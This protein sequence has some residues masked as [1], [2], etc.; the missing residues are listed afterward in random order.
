M[1]QPKSLDYDWW[2]KNKPKSI[3]GAAVEPL[4]K[5]LAGAQADKVKMVK[6]YEH[7]GELAVATKIGASIDAMAKLA[8]ELKRVSVASLKEKHADFAKG[9]E[10]LAAFATADM[11]AVAAALDVADKKIKVASGKA[12]DITAANMTTAAKVLKDFATGEKGLL[13][14]ATKAIAT[15]AAKGQKATTPDVFKQAFGE[16]KFLASWLDTRVKAVKTDVKGLMADLAKAGNDDAAFAK[17]VK[18]QLAVDALNISIGDWERLKDGLEKVDKAV[19][20]IAAKVLGKGPA[21]KAYLDAIE[22]PVTLKAPKAT[23]VGLKLKAQP[24]T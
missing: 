16:S 22:I 24:K 3:Q 23:G 21:S 9:C 10:K 4:I 6:M 11:K 17:G 13:G 15:V 8:T 1:D 14:E 5:E 7:S 2:K 19:L 18:T 20:A 12:D